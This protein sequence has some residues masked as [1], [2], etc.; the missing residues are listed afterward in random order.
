MGLFISR[1][2]TEYMA[3]GHPNDQQL[4]IVKGT[5]RK[6][7][8]FKYRGSWLISSMMDFTPEVLLHSRHVTN[9]G[10]CGN[11]SAVL[12]YNSAFSVHVLNLSFSMGRK[13]GH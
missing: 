13:H 1:R 5:I 12:Q 6:V 3:I 9:S 8:D 2:K 4:S 7:D 11:Q 10:E